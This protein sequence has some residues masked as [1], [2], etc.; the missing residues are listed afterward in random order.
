MTRSAIPLA[1][2][3]KPD[4]GFTLVELMVTLVITVALL[5]IAVPSMR[6]F[7]ARKRLEGVAGELLTDLRYLRSMQVERGRPMRIRFSTTDSTTCYVLFIEGRGRGADCDCS[8]QPVCADVAGAAEQ[9]KTVAVQRSGG[10]ELTAEPATL[11]LVGPNGM[12]DRDTT[13]VASVSSP[14]G[15]ALRVSTN[16]AALPSICSVSGSNSSIPNCAP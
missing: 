10:I 15:G 8:R 12:P 9:L 14:V 6:E 1:A 11:L 5:A 4:V 7:I 16:Q 3:R 13:L 2:P